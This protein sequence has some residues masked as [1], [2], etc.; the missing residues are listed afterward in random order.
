VAAR[1]LLEGVDG[2]DARVAE[3]GEGAG[4]PLEAGDAVLVLEE[5]FRQDLDGDVP[6]ELRVA[7]PVDLPHPPRAERGE[8]LPGTETG[9]GCETQ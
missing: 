5:L 2:G 8:N 7:G 4:L 6:L 9:A 3:G 1:D